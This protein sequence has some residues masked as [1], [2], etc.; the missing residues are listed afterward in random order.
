MVYVQL[1]KDRKMKA[2]IRMTQNV[3]EELSRKL[4]TTAKREFKRWAVENKYGWTEHGKDL[5]VTGFIAGGR[6]IHSTEKG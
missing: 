2:E 6:Y 5:W 3:K 1:G 4:P